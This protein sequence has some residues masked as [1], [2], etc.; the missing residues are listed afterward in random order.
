[1]QQIGDWFRGIKNDPRN[2]QRHTSLILDR[3]NIDFWWL[4]DHIQIRFLTFPDI[5]FMMKNLYNKLTK[6]EKRLYDGVLGMGGF[7]QK[8]EQDPK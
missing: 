4:S 3:E 7:K 6:Q 8:Y 1:M 5:D 2:P